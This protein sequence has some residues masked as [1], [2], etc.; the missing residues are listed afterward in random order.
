[1]QGSE[2]TINSII[3][4]IAKSTRTLI[5]LCSTLHDHIFMNQNKMLAQQHDQQP[6]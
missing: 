3:S 6:N 5:N 2:N 1:M 4:L